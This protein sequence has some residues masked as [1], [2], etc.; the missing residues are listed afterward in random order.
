[1]NA[2]WWWKHHDDEFGEGIYEIDRTPF[3]LTVRRVGY[4]S[5]SPVIELDGLSGHRG[6]CVQ[7]NVFDLLAAAGLSVGLMAQ[8]G[9]RCYQLQD[10]REAVA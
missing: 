1:M 5:C 8:S 4:Q 7:F 9:T 3:E 10:E 2:V 6:E